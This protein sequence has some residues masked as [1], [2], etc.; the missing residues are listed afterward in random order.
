MMTLRYG[1]TNT[2]YIEGLL[3][4]TDMAGTLGGF[5]GELGRNGLRLSD[6]KFVLATHYHPDHAGLVGEL[7]RLGVKL[8]LIDS[9]REHAHFQDGIFARQKN[10]KFYPVDE[11]SAV[12]LSCGES[13]EFLKSIGVKGEIVPTHSHSP[14]GV[15]LVLDSGECFAGDLEPRQYIEF[16]GGDSELARDWARIT[17]LSPKT[18]Y[19]GH[20]NAQKT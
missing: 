13:R 17:A 7:Q 3:V 8:L 2:Y 19:F 5:Y 4:D 15:A 1:N 20:I 18:V 10:V 14:D 11:G 9:Q 12:V 6:V 16:Y